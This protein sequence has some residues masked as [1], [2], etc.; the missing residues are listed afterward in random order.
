MIICSN[1]CQATFKQSVKNQ[2]AEKVTPKVQQ[3]LLIHNKTRDKNRSTSM[4][5]AMDAWAWQMQR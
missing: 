1:I 4:G 2:K 5:H 3:S